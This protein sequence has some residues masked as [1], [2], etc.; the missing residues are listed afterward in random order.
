MAANHANRARVLPRSAATG[1]ESDTAGL[2]LR[3]PLVVILGMTV[4]AALGAWWWFII[5]AR[6]R[7]ED[8]E[9]RATPTTFG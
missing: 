6:R 3:N 5:I 2:T 7:D 8:A 9:T 1:N 4:I